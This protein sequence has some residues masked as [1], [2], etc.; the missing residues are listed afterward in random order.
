M[1]ATVKSCL[2]AGLLLLAG[3]GEDPGAPAPPSPPVIFYDWNDDMPQTVLQEFAQE[4]GVRVEYRGYESQE[5]AVANLLAGEVH[6]VVVVDLDALPGLVEAGRLAPLDYRNIPNFKHVGADFRDLAVDP[7]NRHS[8]PYH[9]G[10]TG[11]LVR[12]DLVGR[13]VR[14]WADLWDP[15]LGGPIAVRREMREL[16]GLTQL[17]LGQPL[18]STDPE[19]LRLAF[20]RLVALKPQLLPVPVAAD[21]AVPRLLAGDAVVLVGWAEDYRLAR[22]QNPAVE[23]VVPAEG[24]GLWG[25][26]FVVPASSRQRALAERLIDFLQRPEISARIVNEKSYATANATARAL[27]DPAI[28]D[29]P[30]AYPP[31]ERLRRMSFYRPLGAQ[32][33][34]AYASAW[35]RFLDGGP[36]AAGRA[37]TGSE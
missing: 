7:G 1:R 18:D 12:T 8:V 5:K 30:V 11:L 34:Q 37:A 3:C 27:I 35:R 21:E 6:D 16:I 29:D 4:H 32:G 13:P 15:A 14:R 24:T 10:I 31:A 23:F 2:C 19:H 26:A 36:Y 25:D 20:E 22:A 33:E 17:S 28:R 9:F